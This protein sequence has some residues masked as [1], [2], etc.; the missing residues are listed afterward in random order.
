MPSR[1]RPSPILAEAGDAVAIEAAWRAV[2]EIARQSIDA[3]RRRLAGEPVHY[4]PPDEAAQQT[5]RFLEQLS[6]E[7]LDLHAIEPRLVRLCH[8]LDHLAQLHDD[9]RE[10]APPVGD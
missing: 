10:V 1:K 4:D 6:L 9:L 7:T 5:E 8:A 2:L 3:V